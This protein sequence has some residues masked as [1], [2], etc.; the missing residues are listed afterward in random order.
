VFALAVE[1]CLVA[2][3]FIWAHRRQV[4]DRERRRRVPATQLRL[5]LEKDREVES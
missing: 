4:R 5:P 1:I 2:A 3:W